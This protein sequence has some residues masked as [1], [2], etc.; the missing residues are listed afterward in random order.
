MTMGER[1]RLRVDFTN[2]FYKIN[3][4]S[5]EDLYLWATQSSLFYD[6]FYARFE[7]ACN[8]AIEEKRFNK[9]ERT[10]KPIFME[11]CAWEIIPSN[12]ADFLRGLLNEAGMERGSEYQAG[13]MIYDYY[14][15][16]FKDSQNQK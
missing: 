5:A 16:H 8:K 1:A 9:Y 6:W 7:E 15:A 3:K 10:Y 13:Q 2:T 4:T 12:Y 14:L 11:W